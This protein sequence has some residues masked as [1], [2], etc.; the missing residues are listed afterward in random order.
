M[1]RPRTPLGSAGKMTAVGQVE[2]DDGRW[3]TA[4]AGRKPIRWRARCKYR[5]QDGKLRDVEA[6]AETKGKAETRLHAKLADRKAP[7][8][9]DVL[10][11]DMSVSDAAV[12]WLAQV[13]RPDSGLSVGTK[14]Q[15]RGAYE[16]HVKDSSI[17]G[18]TLREVNRLPVLEGYLQGVADEHGTGSA[19][20]ARSV[21]SG[22]L[23]MAVRHGV[24]DF[25]AM[26]EVRPAKAIEPKTTA[27]DTRRALTRDERDRF[28]KSINASEKATYLDVAD[29]A[30]YI[31]GT[32]V[33]IG[34]ALSQQWADVDLS[35]GTVLVRGTKT[36]HSQRVLTLPNWLH[37]RL[38]ERADTR[39]ADG[40]LFPSPGR[41]SKGEVARVA[42][43]DADKP[44][45]QRNVARVLRE[46]LDNAG[47]PWA[48]PHSLRRTVATMIDEAG[49]PIALAA[50]Q[51]GHSNPAMTAS[52]YLG[53]KG[54]T[55][56]AAGVL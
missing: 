9:G 52:V 50:N 20:V 40:H 54:D 12:A 21:V 41:L 16:R 55:S 49:L 33:R 14:F 35:K 2:R 30:W 26:R 15:Y 34:E 27:R 39:G 4:P 8:S 18:L 51:L 19:K 17:A 25:N 38:R 24:L 47:L 56:A 23:R 42:K 7:R 22:V 31:A 1:S 11:A 29:I 46:E 3:I 13:D 44:R 45:E 53:R 6:F 48:T 43:P 36:A 32:G 10:R 37:N 28:L 5:D